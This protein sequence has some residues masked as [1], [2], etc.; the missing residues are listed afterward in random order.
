MV[1]T[2]YLNLKILYYSKFIKKQ[3]ENL[4]YF[5]KSLFLSASPT[6]QALTKN[7]IPSK[8]RCCKVQVDVV[9]LADTYS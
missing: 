8:I 5:K 4:E 9:E 2:L 1:W 7:S 6:D 3:G